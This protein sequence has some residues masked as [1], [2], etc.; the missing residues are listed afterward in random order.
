MGKKVN[1]FGFRLGVLYTWKS[2][3]FANARDYK[4]LLLQDLELRKFVM[5]KLKN[6]GI[7]N[8]DIERSIK[9]IKIYVYVSRPGVVIGRGGSG[10]EILK[11]E[12]MKQ[13]NI[14]ENDPKAVKLDVKVEEIKN[15]NAHAHSIA[16]RLSD[17]LIARYPHRRAVKQAIDNAMDA[18]VK[19][20]KIQLAGRIGGA[21]I[22]RVEKYGKGT[23]PTQTIRADIDYDEIPA[24]TKSGYVGIKVWVNNGE[25]RI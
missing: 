21:E 24:L 23:V 5:A 15:P 2:R 11:K 6:A 7:I 20:V 25:K 17:Q 22:A 1:P 9:K 14:K 12:I 18:G 8:V 16:Q 4:T 10:M 19:G 13:L 3:W